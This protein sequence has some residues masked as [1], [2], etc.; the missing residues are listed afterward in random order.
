[1]VFSETSTVQAAMIVD[2]V[3]AGW[4]HTPGTALARDHDNVLIE[5]E[6]VAAVQRLNPSF[7]GDADRVD[8]VMTSLRLLLVNSGDV[9]LMSA[10]EEFTAW[11]RGRRTIPAAHGG[12]DEPVRLIDFDNP[13]SN[14][15]VVSDEVTYGVPGSTARFDIVLWVNGIPLVVGET[16]TPVDSKKS[17]VHAAKDIRDSYETERPHFFVPNLLSFA[18]EGREFRY[19]PI[20]TPLDR[21]E[22]WGN[23]Q[24]DANLDGWPR[25]QLSVAGLLS[26]TV[27]LSILD[28]YAVYERD[29][30]AIVKIVPRYF[31]HETVEAIV[32]RVVA[33]SPRRGLIYHTQ[34]SGK[35][36]AMSW[37]AARLIHEPALNNPTIVVIADRS[38]LVRQTYDQFLSTGTPRLNEVA[39]SAQLRDLLRSEQRGVIFTTI[40]KFRD[41]G[42]L[43]TRD[44]IVVLIDEAHRTQEG[45]LGEQMRAALPNAYLFGFTGT[46]IADLDRNTF[47]LFGYEG[48]PDY[49]LNTYNS[50]R[51]IADGTTVPMRVSSRMVEFRID[52]ATLDA[53]F[54]ALAEAEGL[55]DADKEKVA[56]KLS[57]VAT[58]LSNPERIRAVCR[59]I[60]DHFYSTIDPLGMKAQIVVYNRE[61]CIAYHRELVA[62]LAERGEDEA[63][64][65]MSAQ[66]KDD[67]A[68]W[69]E[70]R[71]SESQEEAILNRF[72]AFGD[73]MKFLIVTS[74]LG[75]GFNAPIEGVLYLDKP[76]KLHTLFQTITRTNRPWSNPVTGQK[77]AYGLVVDYIGLGD[78]FARAMTPG[79]PD[80]AQRDIDLDGL[81]DVFNAELDNILDRFAG[82][83]RDD[84]SMESLQASLSRVP[85]GEIR[86][87]FAAQ[88]MLLQSLW[89]TI[90]PNVQLEPRKSEYRWLAKVYQAVTPTDDSA[91]L[92]DRIGSK[93]LDLVYSN[94]SGVAVRN[95]K[96]TVQIADSRTIERLVDEGLL[97]PDDTETVNKPASEV[98]DGIMSRLRIRL[99]GPNGRHIIYRGLAERLERLRASE[100]ARATDSIEFL[101]ELFSLAKDV[102]VA[103]LAEDSAGAA[104]LDLLPDPNIGALTQIFE[105]FKPADTPVIIGDIVLEIDRIVRQVRYPGWVAHDAG[106]R[107]VRRALLQVFKTFRLPLTGEPLESAYRYIETHY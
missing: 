81:I 15:F 102:R 95:P 88:F 54:D 1:M 11:L 107:N 23:T 93:T 46:P 3:A 51:S 27:L 75:T 39:S 83:D 33:A 30:A 9:G 12:L 58:L 60:L 16:K 100:L 85:P 21:W 28:H 96:V 97:D 79:N 56:S 101:R 53:E 82:I 5:S 65:I 62:L 32:G 52:Q 29:G 92:W 80:A 10:N 8:A 45:L 43:S 73:P 66:G 94:I 61:M 89:E 59:D 4:T 103:E 13:S 86:E 41:A 105:E 63:A 90:S 74:K 44:N 104:G 78:G 106:K 40:H 72:R 77:K 17:W 99:A 36:L 6:L 91:L 31:Q 48:D 70:Y 38:Q 18:S 2:L 84:M 68:D 71:L 57:N 19:A 20:Q 26:P 47:K 76:M 42:L 7:A 49:S 25:V 55:D 69:D 64:V 98:I 24:V 67:P 37:A 87:R 14:K 34:G 35:T 22:Q 50:D